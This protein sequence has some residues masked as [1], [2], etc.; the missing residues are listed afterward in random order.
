MLQSFNLSSNLRPVAVVRLRCSTT[1]Y[2]HHFGCAPLAATPERLMH[3]AFWQLL[4]WCFHCTKIMQR[5]K[6]A[7]KQQLTTGEQSEHE[8]LVPSGD[9]IKQLTPYEAFL[10]SSPMSCAMRD[11]LCQ[12]APCIRRSFFFSKTFHVWQ[13][14]FFVRS[15]SCNRMPIF[16][17]KIFFIMR[18]EILIIYSYDL[19][20]LQLQ[21]PIWLQMP[22]SHTS[23]S[24][25]LFCFN[26]LEL[27][28]CTACSSFC[29]SIRIIRTWWRSRLVESA[30]GLAHELTPFIF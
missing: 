6:S 4:F 25:F 24:F 29:I 30:V 15:F 5:W 12:Q 18:P 16:V 10:V 27:S 22:L 17:Q 21:Q 23:T 2:Q 20:V 8:I 14:A 19:W 7:R 9:A 3:V 28:S 26:V 13:E 1:E 11:F